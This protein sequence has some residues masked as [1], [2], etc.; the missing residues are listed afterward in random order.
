MPDERETGTCQ[1][2]FSGNAGL[3]LNVLF[4]PTVAP[5][6]L[7]WKS[8]LVYCFPCIR[9]LCQRCAVGCLWRYLLP[10]CFVYRDDDFFGAAALGNH[11]GK[12][13][14]AAMESDTDW[15]R[16]QDLDGIRGKRPQLFEGEI[17]PNDLCQGAVG[18]W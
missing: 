16:A 15:V 8:L 14:G 10:C 9:V 5:I 1:K 6:V 3:C 7:I 13:S 12:Q 18:D 11:E 4:C 17:E 2:I